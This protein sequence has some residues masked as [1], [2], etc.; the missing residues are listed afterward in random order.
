[1][2]SRR[3]ISIVT[4]CYNE[5]A[6]VLSHFDRVCRAIAPFRETYDFE[7]I[8]TD[9]QSQDATFAILSGLA[10]AN[11]SVKVL[12]FARN[13]GPNRAVFIGLQKARGDA[14]ILIQA[15]L[16]DP[17]ELLPDFIRGWQEGFDVV[18]GRIEEREERL[19]LRSFRRL[20]YKLIASLSE[21]PVP[22]N[23]GEFRLTSRRALD[24]L[25]EYND[26]DPYI[27]GIVASVGYPQKAVPYAR[28]ARAGGRSSI[29]LFGLVGFA[30]NGVLSTTVAPL[31]AVILMGLFLSG[32]GFL[33]TFALI[34]G[35]VLLPNAAPQGVPMIAALITFFSGS[36]MLA[37]GIIAEY[38][39]KIYFQSLERPRGFIQDSLNADKP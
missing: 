5:E 30:I 23:V 33:L 19:V 32:L 36:Q 6:N 1:M 7:H 38:V 21:V 20:Y 31:R 9:N 39:R 16:Q 34:V 17:P 15:D 26:D 18:Y 4:P 37:M 27:R 10:Q 14:A 24:G 2:N 8:Y 22:E 11:P 35:K 12:R 25:L 3:L 28:A 13:I 29:S